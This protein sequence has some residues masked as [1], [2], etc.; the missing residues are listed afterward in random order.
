MVSVLLT[1]AENL[2]T[3]CSCALTFTSFSQ[4]CPGVCSLGWWWTA[5]IDKGLLLTSQSKVKYIVILG[6]VGLV[7]MD[8][9]EMNSVYR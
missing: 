3:A 9:R 2:E 7:K 5:S 1:P 4:V 8:G 6:K